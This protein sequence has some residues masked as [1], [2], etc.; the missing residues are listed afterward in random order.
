MIY[1]CLLYVIIL[2]TKSSK[3]SKM[4]NLIGHHVN[5]RELNLTQC[6]NRCTCSYVLV[7]FIYVQ[8]L[9]FNKIRWVEILRIAVSYSYQNFGVGVGIEISIIYGWGWGFI[10]FWGW[11]WGC[12][13]ENF[14]ETRFYLSHKWLMANSLVSLYAYLTMKG[15][16]TISS[17]ATYLH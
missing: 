9:I 17:L 1:W 13:W 11:G 12:S 5:L 3:K 2:S 16:S 14:E 6:L 10:F 7:S 15:G 4:R 8:L